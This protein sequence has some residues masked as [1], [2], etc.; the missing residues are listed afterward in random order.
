MILPRFLCLLLYY[1][2]AN[3]LYP[4]E[5]FVLVRFIYNLSS[6]SS[7][8]LLIFDF[9]K[10]VLMLWLCV[11]TGSLCL[12]HQILNL[13]WSSTLL[14]SYIFNLLQ[15]L[16]TCKSLPSQFCKLPSLFS[17][18]KIQVAFNLYWLSASVFHHYYEC[19]FLNI[20]FFLIVFYYMQGWTATTRHGVT[21]KRSIKRSKH[22][23]NLFTKNLQLIVV[24]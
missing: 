12:R 17:V 20:G 21:R 5:R 14:T 4:L 3:F 7:W 1:F 24:F 13:K 9:T 23:V 10:F 18:F 8:P 22:T 19:T 16:P 15:I 6:E 11:A 2:F